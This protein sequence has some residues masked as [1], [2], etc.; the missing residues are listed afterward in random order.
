MTPEEH[1][2]STLDTSLAANLA[3]LRDIAREL[4]ASQTYIVRGAAYADLFTVLPLGANLDDEVEAPSLI[5][6]HP[7]ATIFVACFPS[8]DGRPAGIE[9]ATFTS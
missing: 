8:A 9:I 6:Q 7:H 4:G 5:L 2:N 1:T 3:E